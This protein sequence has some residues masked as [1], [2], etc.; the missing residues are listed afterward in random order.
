MNKKIKKAS[1]VV[2]PFILLLTSCIPPVD[3]KLE[4]IV[5]KK[6]Q[7]TN[8][9]TSTITGT[10]SLIEGVLSRA[11]ISGITIKLVR[12]Y[13]P[14]FK[15]TKISDSLGNK[16]ISVNENGQFI[17]PNVIPGDFQLQVSGF[18][19]SSERN[20]SLKEGEVKKIDNIVLGSP[21]KTGTIVTTKE[22]IL[23]G[24]VFLPNGDIAPKAIVADVTKGFTSIK[25]EAGQD[26]SFAFKTPPFSTPKTLEVTLGKVTTSFTV[27]PDQTEN[28]EI[29]LLENSR[30][31]IGR[32]I[33]S[34]N[35]KPVENLQVIVSDT[36]IGAVTNKNGEFI[37]KGVPLA[38]TNIDIGGLSGYIQKKQAIPLGT[39]SD[40]VDLKTIE[41]VPLGNLL[42]NVSIEDSI[43]H[44][45]FRDLPAPD[46]NNKYTRTTV[47]RL[48]KTH[49]DY[50]FYKSFSDMI[51]CGNVAT[52][53]SSNTNTGSSQRAIYYLSNA[54]AIKEPL[55]G[56]VQ[57]EGTDIVKNFVYPVTPSLDP[58]P[59]CPI[60]N[61]IEKKAATVYLENFVTTISIPGL[62]G[63]EYSISISISG[64]ETQK[65]IKIVVPSNDT[66][67]TENI[68]LKLVKRIATVGDVTGK[69]MFKDIAGNKLIVQV[70][71]MACQ[72][73]IKDLLLLHH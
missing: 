28:I 66:I 5:I 55:Q 10:V 51:F 59:E 23:S 53:S 64:H 47:S 72:Q 52:Q 68:K 69:V 24:K 63:G 27:Q 48:G 58:K 15:G 9:K 3:S 13:P 16:S 56:V 32:I 26:G 37:I 62:P 67:S 6:V 19:T 21:A 22:I 54:Y 30:P 40:Q 18:G 34:V 14:N 17:I 49:D 8:P 41:I 20:F 33:D 71:L 35:K 29:P 12:V 38:P 73:L 7:I 36:S 2:L 4:E 57:L 46:A 11:S 25:V 44:I 1:L 45:E 31:I 39:T 60:P 43:D 50:D 70:F 65:G 61:S 42:V